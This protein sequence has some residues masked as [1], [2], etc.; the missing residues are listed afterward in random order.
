MLFIRVN[1]SITHIRKILYHLFDKKNFLKLT[2]DFNKTKAK[3]KRSAFASG[4]SDFSRSEIQTK[5]PRKFHEN[6]SI[7]RDCVKRETRLEICRDPWH[8]CEL[9][10]RFP[11]RRSETSSN[12]LSADSDSRR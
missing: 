8:A 4:T 12:S 7:R 2:L 5:I 9:G 11:W 1:K 10:T 3:L 6:S